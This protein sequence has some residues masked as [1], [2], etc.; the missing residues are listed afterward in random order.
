MNFQVV[1]SNIYRQLILALL[2]D[3]QNLYRK[4]DI[5][6]ESHYSSFAYKS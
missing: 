1:K 2:T 6:S 3:R 5:Q 4:S